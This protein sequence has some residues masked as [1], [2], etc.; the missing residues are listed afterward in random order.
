MAVNLSVN[1]S[2]TVT[3]G[4]D[5]KLRANSTNGMPLTHDDVD[6]NFEALRL[7]HNTVVTALAGKSASNHTHSNA[8]TSSHGFMSSSYVTK[9]NGI[10]TNANNYALP[11]ASSSVRG[12]VKLGFGTSGR[13]YGVSQSSEKLYVNVPW[14]DTVFNGG[15]ITA[16]LTIA[17]SSPR[18][19]LRDSNHAKT[20]NAFQSY[21]QFLDKSTAQAGYVGYSS[22]SN[23]VLTVYNSVDRVNIA[24]TGFTYNNNAVL[25][26]GS[27]GYSENGK[28]YPVESDSSGKLYV[29]V[30]WS[31]SQL[32]ITNDPTGTNQS[33]ALSQYAG[34]SLHNRIS[35]L[36]SAGLVLGEPERINISGTWRTWPAEVKWTAADETGDQGS[37]SHY[38]LNTNFR[39]TAP[40]S[41]SYAEISPGLG[42]SLYILEDR[43][44]NNYSS[45]F[46]QD[47]LLFG[48]STVLNDQIADARA[49]AFVDWRQA[50]YG[51]D[52]YYMLKYDYRNKHAVMVLG[53]YLG[54]AGKKIYTPNQ[55]SSNSG[56]YFNEKSSRRYRLTL[57]A[58]LRSGSASSGFYIGI[59]EKHGNTNQ[60]DGSGVDDGGGTQPAS[61]Q[62]YD[63]YTA[64]TGDSEGDSS[65]SFTQGINPGYRTKQQWL[66]NNGQIDNEWQS[67]TY[68]FTIDPETIWFNPLIL[69]G[70]INEE[71]HWHPDVYIEEVDVSTSNGYAS[72]TQSGYSGALGNWGQQVLNQPA[73]G[74]DWVKNGNLV[75]CW[76]DA[77][78][79]GSLDASGY[80]SFDGLP[81]PPLMASTSSTTRKPASVVYRNEVGAAALAPMTI[82][83]GKLHIFG[84]ASGLPMPN[85]NGDNRLIG[86]ISYEIAT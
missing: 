61:H 62:N 66:L 54:A 29:N 57:Y 43:V 58:R 28:N 15:T 84:G 42:P 19:D 53:T 82:H 11:L 45:R 24:A 10:A 37:F 81:F 36:E 13:N 46:S 25:H 22:N 48:S 60:Q 40:N 74:L 71:V 65:S 2:F 35:T 72:L 70:N 21:I 69:K 18:I 76:L 63:Y 20:E 33:I 26:N 51:D 86:Q 80:C 44:F 67:Y 79:A 6:S 5:I 17:N 56:E 8:T 78:N 23:K 32:G 7:A 14:T 75:T 49:M 77:P 39:N 68:E 59:A 38:T 73:W 31:N 34:W 12:G 1:G 52:D 4:S 55:A 3:S 47:T 83:S 41:P 30:P 16:A 64:N 9:L 27:L 50:Y 85:G